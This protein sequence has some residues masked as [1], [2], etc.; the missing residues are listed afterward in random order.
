MYTPLYKEK[1]KKS[2][3]LLS[4]SKV[5]STVGLAKK[6]QSYFGQTKG[7]L[8]LHEGLLIVILAFCV[9]EL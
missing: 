7:H 2:S 9:Y 8:K 6:F 1:E 3:Y 5:F 4:K